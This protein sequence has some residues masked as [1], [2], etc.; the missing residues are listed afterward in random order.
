MPDRDPPESEAGPP[1][2]AASGVAGARPAVPGPQVGALLATLVRPHR[3]RLLVLLLFALVQTLSAMA[4]P[5]LVGVGIDV[6]L[7]RA[8][9]GDSVPIFAIGVAL[10]SCAVLSAFLNRL[11]IRGTGLVG[12]QLLFELRRTLF[13]HIQ[14]LP[15]AFHERSGSGE[16][17]S[18]LTSDVAALDELLGNAL[19]NLIGATLNVIVIAVLM[20]CLNLELAGVTLLSVFP[21]AA[22]TIWFSLRSATAFG[23][24]RVAIA[25]VIAHFVES[26]NGIR[27]VQAFRREARSEE[28]FARLA[29]R[30]RLA[31]RQAQRLEIVYWPGLELIFSLTTVI[32]LVVG[33]I[34]VIDGG[35][36][37]GVLAAFLLYV[38]QFF[39]PMTSMTAFFGI[40]QSAMAALAKIAGVLSVRTHVPEPET[41]VVLK[42]PVRGTIALHSVSFG[43]LAE[44]PILK[45]VDFRVPAGQTVA[46]V[47][48]TGAGKSTIAKIIARFHDPVD[49]SV[50]L[51]GIDLRDIAD[52]Q[53]RR[54]I[55]LVTQETF[56]FSGSVADN[57]AFGAPGA[58][59]AQVEQAAAAVGADAFIRALPQGYETDVHKGGALL[60]EG[61]RQLITIARAFLADPAV[62]IL[63]EA[64][65]SLDVPS[66]RVVQDALHSLLHGRTALIIA[67]RLST[68]SIADRVLVLDAGR[69]IEDGAPDEL[70]ARQDGAFTA[71]HRSW[72]DALA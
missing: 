45:E 1:D 65:S 54:S 51:D 23:R 6:G 3:A 63:D 46:L 52:R 71:L 64:T 21:M 67:H 56:L 13:D 9:H 42:E 10:A 15:V 25:R 44:K 7:P 50:T 53:L 5:W 30:Y 48:A 34:R 61:Q 16:I 33:G 17:I 19:T 58:P 40:L 72:D 59:R 66:E 26:L 37:I 39:G 41:P 14:R 12:Q 70:L 35:L 31:N 68:V 2:G 11:W 28:Q 27:A 62:L 20:L 60:S 4:G 18:R 69:V 29:D 22:L 36:P 38:T 47:G 43:Y 24:T 57:I 55:V 8:Q 49:G 32:V